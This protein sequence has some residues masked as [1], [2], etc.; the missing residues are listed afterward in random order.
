MN[1][2]GMRSSE[3]SV[4]TGLASGIVWLSEACK[5]PWLYVAEYVAVHI[6]SIFKVLSEIEL[7]S[8]VVEKR[9]EFQLREVCFN[10]RKEE[11]A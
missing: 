7:G 2:W 8:Q 11:H 3:V 9:S 6:V 10:L 5:W 4:R 1:S